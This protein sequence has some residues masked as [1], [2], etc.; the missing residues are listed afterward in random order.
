[1]TVAGRKS[2][3][4]ALVEIFACLAVLIGTY[5]LYKVFQHNGYLPAPFVFDVN[6]TFMDWFNTAYWGHRPG[7]YEV[8]NSV[9][10][11]ISFVFTQL[12]GDPRCYANSPFDARD[13]D[14]IGIFVLIG[15]YALAVIVSG[16]AFHRNDRSTWILRTIGIMLG[17]PML[18]ALERGNI[19]MLAYIA[20]VLLYGGFLKRGTSIAA[21]AAVMINLKS[22]LVLPVLGLAT[23]RRWRMLELCGIATILLYL[24]SLAWIG[25]GTPFQ[26]AHDLQVWF[27]MRAGAVWDELLYTTTYKPYLLFD[28]RQYPIR[29]FVPQRV[30]DITTIAI[31]V[32]LILSRGIAWL[33]IAAA[34]FYPGQ[35]PMRRVALLALMQ[36]FLM[37]NP[38]GYAISFIAFLAFMEQEKRFAP[39]FAIVCC[40]LVSVPTD[41][42]LTVF[43]HFPRESWLSGRLVDS[44]YA[45]PVGALIRPG[46]LLGVVWALSIDSLIAVHREMR[47][48]PPQ[49]GLAPFPWQLRAR[50]TWA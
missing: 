5:D 35:V 38:G 43:Y 39:M 34:W 2:I 25:E 20:F 12:L 40:Y 33:T 22:Y 48:S 23:Q 6:D 15:S 46:L 36:S 10:A 19:I 7:A 26:I 17:G 49:I 47:R 29:D 30:I 11:P 13:C 9:Y 21:A 37:Q 50:P 8:W 1:M 42:N 31:N 24:A 45:L 4:A 44:A 18:F 27:N 32:E 14:T 41:V 16:I 28:E 3:V